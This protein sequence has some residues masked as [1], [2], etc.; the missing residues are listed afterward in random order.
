MNSRYP[1]VEEMDATVPRYVGAAAERVLHARGQP[2][3]LMRIFERSPVPMVIVNGDRRYVE[4]NRP[5]RLAFRLTLSELRALRIDDLTPPYLLDTT[6]DA[7]SRLVETGC[8]AG[9]YEVAGLDGGSFGIAYWAAA[10]ALPGLH[11]I[12]FAPVGWS[13]GDLL[14]DD[15]LEA[16]PDVSLTPRELEILELAADGHSGPAIAEQ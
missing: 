6:E 15:D 13:D 5:A 14:E 1:A 12:A 11:L 9:G 7:W 4:V 3:R 10:D 16:M 8:V 2:E